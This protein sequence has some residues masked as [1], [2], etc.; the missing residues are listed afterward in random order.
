MGLTRVKGKVELWAGVWRDKGGWIARIEKRGSR[1]GLWHSSGF[2][3]KKAAEE[4][5]NEVLKGVG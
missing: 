3:T 2:G 5:M 4:W 1:P